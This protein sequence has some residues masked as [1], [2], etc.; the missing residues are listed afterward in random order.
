MEQRAV[1]KFRAKSKKTATETFELIKNAYSEES[2]TRRSMSESHQ[3]FREGQ[4]SLQGN[5]WNDS[6]STARTEECIEVIQKSLAEDRTSSVQML[7][8]ITEI[9]GEAVHKILVKDL[10]KEIILCPF[11]SSFVNARSKTLMRCIVCCIC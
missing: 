7:E 9:N 6:P 1:I 2:L 10:K 11:G 8:E 5:E 3:M 4:E